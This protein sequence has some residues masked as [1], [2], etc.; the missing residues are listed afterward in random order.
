MCG[1]KEG[2]GQRRTHVIITLNPVASYRRPPSSSIERFVSSRDSQT[3]HL[4]VRDKL[5]TGLL[6]GGHGRHRIF[7]QPNAVQLRFW[8]IEINLSLSH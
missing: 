4:H 1:G 2:E 7:Q 6:K 5:L 3:S 8:P